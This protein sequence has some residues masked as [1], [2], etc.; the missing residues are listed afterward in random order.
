MNKY[1]SNKLRHH[2]DRVAEYVADQPGR[3]ITAQ[4]QIIDK[5]FFRCFYCDKEIDRG[6]VMKVDDK[7]INRLKELGVLSVILTGGEPLMYPGFDDLL[8]K[9]DKHFKI[10]IVTTLYIY[11]EILETVPAW[12]KI[13]LDS[14]DPAKYGKIK[15]V[16][17]K[18]LD[19]VL[20][21]MDRL[22]KNKNPDIVL[23]TQMVITEDNKTVE[24]IEK[25]YERV[26]RH[27][28]Y[29]QLR[30]LEMKEPYKYPDDVY[31]MLIYVRDKYPKI[32]VSEKF[33]TAQLYNKCYARWTQLLVA[34]NYDVMICCNRVHEKVANL[35]DENLLNEIHTQEL[36]MK[37]CY[38]PCVMSVYNQ[39][40]HNVINGDHK[41]FV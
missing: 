14:I 31:K 24:Q 11:K 16:A 12:I 19:S 6:T 26:H 17:P 8:L 36:D 7:L 18:V 33:Y 10:G 13:S 29:L 22:Y 32:T 20:K 37:K 41:E 3:P 5:C 40:M 35:F 21:N 4:L 27:C 15:G 39:Y 9:L 34:S 23:G 28:D 1:I 25:V 30:P 2:P 38:S